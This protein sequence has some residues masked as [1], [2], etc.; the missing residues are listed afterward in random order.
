MSVSAVAGVLAHHVRDLAPVATYEL[1]A[2][3][4]QLRFPTGWLPTQFDSSLAQPARVAVCGPHPDGGWDGCETISLF[5]F[6]GTPS[7]GL[8]LDASDRM[9]RDLDA[10][11]ITTRPLTIPSVSQITA[12][13]SSGYFSAAEQCIWLQY[14]TYLVGSESPGGATLIEHSI[15]VD[16]AR[17]AG[18]RD[19][20]TQ[21]SSAVHDTFISTIA[22]ASEQN[23]HASACPG[24]GDFQHSK[25]TELTVFRVGFFPH[26]KWDDAVVLIS[27]DRDGMRVFQAAIRSAHEGGEAASELHGIQHR[28]VRQDGAADIELGWQTV[29]WRFDDTM[30][31]EIFEM[32]TR[33]IDVEHPAHD[34]F[35]DLNSPDATLM[36]S[37]DEY[38]DD[39]PFAEFPQGLP[40]PS[41]VNY[42]KRP[43]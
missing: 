39:G 32:I 10:E 27:A 17:R 1:P 3:L 6:T 33:L 2:W 42:R 19:D 11:A 8:V 26:F 36:I 38:I 13:R 21:L 14:S 29:V 12:V 22:A 34:Y 9:M 18:L 5:R 24:I 35:D 31:L 7:E 16:S 4:Q 15:F 25:G 40:I 41:S 20:I 37:V 30:L 23:L 43:L 28:V